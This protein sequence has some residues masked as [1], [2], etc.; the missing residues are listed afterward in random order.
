MAGALL[1]SIFP[2]KTNAGALSFVAGIFKS[3]T[4]TAS[5][6]TQNNSQTLKIL[7]APLAVNPSIGGAEVAI[8]DETALVPQDDIGDGEIIHPN[9]GQ[10]SVYVVRAGDTLSQ[11][12]QMYNVSVNTI[13][14]ANDL[15]GRTISE[16]QTLIILPVSG[17][18][19]TVKNGDT[20]ASIAKRYSGDEKEII[21]FNNLDAGA[22]L[23][24]GTE[25]VIPNGEVPAVV[26]KPGTKP[27]TQFASLPSAGNYYIKPISG[28]RKTQGLHG[29]NGID[30]GAPV[31]TP[32]IAAAGGTVIVSRN[33]G[34]NGGYGN[35]VVILHPNGTQTLYAHLKNS[36]VL[37]GGRVEQGQL[38]GYS[39]NT[40]K[41]TGP[42]LHF[43][44]RGAKNPF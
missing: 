34:W 18:R 9:N 22:K 17:I 35:Y 42:H 43:E 15:S 8:V 37:Q 24:A 23:V 29:Y 7:E 4:Y 32:V 27:T 2:T 3:T 14:W 36:V 19:Y 38:I 13:V 12:A 26:S 25:V 41:S 11:I 20:L 16:G 5:N 39:G 31:G 40:G 28:A 44:V 30:L 33:S 6:G 1:F 10:I 21:A